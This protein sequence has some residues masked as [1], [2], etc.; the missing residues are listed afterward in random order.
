[1]FGLD[2]AIHKLNFT[3]YLQM[4]FLYTLFF[5]ILCSLIS[6][7]DVINYTYKDCYVHFN[8]NVLTVSN[9]KKQIKDTIFQNVDK[10]YY[11]TPEGIELSIMEMKE[12]KISDPQRYNDINSSGQHYEAMDHSSI[13]SIVGPYVSYRYEYHYD[14]GAHPSYGVG[15]TTYDI[16]TKKN[17]SLL[18]FFSQ[19]EI[20]LAL[21]KDK[22]ILDYVHPKKATNLEELRG[23][24]FMNVDS[25]YSLD[26]SSFSFG[27]I[28]GNE[29]IV[30]I[31]LSHDAEVYRGSFEMIS[32][33][34]SIPKELN[35]FLAA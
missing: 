16:E 13:L 14:G 23:E 6:G 24:F 17:F 4:K 21:I 29:V 3:K 25:Q 35:I 34:L 19:K 20:Y 15:L 32:I 28:N 12:L 7:Q 18:D 22:F 1:M 11:L 9:V 33:K 27:E 26:F 31:G 8:S 5:S 10:E 2:F 30:N